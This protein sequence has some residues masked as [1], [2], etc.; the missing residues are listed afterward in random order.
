MNTETIKLGT[1]I[2]SIAQGKVYRAE[3]NDGINVFFAWPILRGKSVGR[4]FPQATFADAMRF[5]GVTPK[6]GC[7]IMGDRLGRLMEKNPLGDIYKTTIEGTML[8]A[9]YYVWHGDVCVQET[10]TLAEARV[11][12][13]FVQSMPTKAPKVK[14]VRVKR[15]A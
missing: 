6:L 14:K 13:G 11:A 3:R 9:T 2:L 15:H 4:G 1:C 5:L 10:H 7:D 12:S 8:G